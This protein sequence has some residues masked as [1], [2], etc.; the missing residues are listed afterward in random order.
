MTSTMD[1]TS[2]MPAIMD[3]GRRPTCLTCSVSDAHQVVYPQLT[4]L[5]VEA[6]FHGCARRDED[7]VLS[8]ATIDCVSDVLSQDGQPEASLWPYSRVQP[9]SEDWFDPN[10]SAY[11]FRAGIVT[12]EPKF[13]RVIEAI[14]NGRPVILA[15]RV[16]DSLLACDNTGRLSGHCGG[17]IRGLHAVLAIGARRG[18][19]PSIR[20]RNSWGTGWGMLGHAD[21]TEEYFR[22]NAI[23]A[24][25]I[26]RN[27]AEI[28]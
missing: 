27:G 28:G 25:L 12:I 22:A 2:Q 20:I 3:Q 21:M 7:A 18:S 5:S 8:G 17:T 6:L 1:M 23:I 24:A 16:R 10:P 19:E 11:K 26:N 14:T 15:I 9:S 4:A 13:V